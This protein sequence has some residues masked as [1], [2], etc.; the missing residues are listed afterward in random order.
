MSSSP[1]VQSVYLGLTIEDASPDAGAQLSRAVLAAMA[2]AFGPEA[3]KVFGIALLSSAAGFVAGM[4]G[5]EPTIAA[6]ERV[7]SVLRLEAAQ[8]APAGSR[9]H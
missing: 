8:E 4:S 2:E 3:T 6:L 9:P 7:V 1:N 5:T